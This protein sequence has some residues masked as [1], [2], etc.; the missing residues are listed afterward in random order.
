MGLLQDFRFGLRLLINSPGFTVVAIMTLALGMGVNSTVFTLVNGVL[1]KGLPFDAPDE[2]VAFTSVIPSRGSRAPVSYPDFLDFQRQSSAFKGLAAT[3]GLTVDL[4]DVNSAAERVTGASIT[5]NT[6]SLLGRRPFMGRDFTAEDESVAAERVAMISYGVWQSRYGGDAGIIGRSIR[7][8]LN[9]YA[10]VGVMAQGEGFPNNPGVWLPLVADQ[11][12]ERRD[13]RNIEVFGRLAPGVSIAQANTEAA[14]IAQRLAQDYPETNKNVGVRVSPYTEGV[15]G[16]PIRTIFIAL[17][18]AVAFVLM[19]AC[20]NVANLLLSRAVRRMRETSIRTAL[21][22]SRWRIVR[23]LLIEC[24]ILSFVA[25]V[26]GLALAVAGVRLFWNAVK[27]TGPPF[28]LNFAMD[29]RVFAF[30]FVVC[31]ATGI[32][33]GLAPALQISRANINENLRD[34]GRGMSGGFRSRRLA[35][36]LLVAEM[37]L[38]VVLLVGAG[39]MVRSFL[40]I[41]RADIGVSTHDIVTA[42][43]TLRNARYPQPSDRIH[44]Q[45]R[46]LERLRA[47]PVVGSVTIASN[48]PAAGALGGPFQLADREI[49]ETDGQPP[50]T[51]RLAVA[52]GYFEAMGLKMLQGRE[53]TASDGAPGAE[54]AIVNALFAARYWPDENPLGKRIRFGTAADAPWSEVVGVSPPIFQVGPPSLNDLTIQPTVYVAYRQEPTQ[55]LTIITRGGQDREALAGALRNELRSLDADMPLFNIRS[56]DETMAQRRWPA[57]VFGALFTIFAIIA[58]VMASVGIYGVTAYGVGQRT[59]EIG[60]RMALGANEREVMWLVLR[61]GLLRV[62]IGLLVGVPAAFA[63]SRVLS[64]ILFGVNASDPVTFLAM[65]AL[66]SAVMIIACIVPARRAMRLHPVEALRVE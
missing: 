55:T 1:F 42:G 26:L 39:L 61:Q 2:I 15:T 7:I 33:F 34:G 35:S 13:Q 51:S 12:R 8:N 53:F 19:I 47:L 5:A 57:R 41:Q 54:A 65:S 46:L 63:L 66:M 22:A 30:F 6:F 18:G 37:A 24:L 44:F 9:T 11:T 62:G 40:Y 52:P 49:S 60:I 4:S 21:G 14:T 43:A 36:I 59:Q 45:E 38:T 16:G 31:V 17:Q 20:A 58:L 27:D 3:T 48:G 28:W 64:S 56:L 23:Q 32:L 10:V 25:G 29:Y 50:G